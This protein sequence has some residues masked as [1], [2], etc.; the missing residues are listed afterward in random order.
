MKNII[1][2]LLLAFVSLT[3]HAEIRVPAGANIQ[4]FINSG[5]GQKIVISGGTY[6]AGFTCVSGLEIVSDG[7]VTITSSTAAPIINLT[8]CTDV[9]LSGDFEIVGNGPS[10]TG[11]PSSQVVDGAQTGITLSGNDRI[12]IDGKIEIHNI[13]GSA[14]DVQ[15]TAVAWKNSIHIRGLT[16]HDAYRGMWL[17]NVAEYVTTSDVN[18]YNNLFGIQVD[19]GNNTF[20][21]AKTIYNS[22]GVKVCGTASGYCDSAN[23]AHG[24]FVALESN[25]NT[26]D[27]VVVDVTVGETFSGCHFIADQS[28]SGHGKIQ[29]INSKGINIIGGQIAAD[30]SLDA[31]SVLSLQSN[32][33]RPALT[34]TPIVAAGGILYAKNNFTDTGPW[35]NNN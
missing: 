6:T 32:Y 16:V 7:H 13:K 20:I 10:Y 8:G 22:V 34:N 15:A 2:T 21:N 3:A 4:Q 28:G 30:I 35:A 1:F 27:L 25:H 23:N 24:V 5:A 17:H 12:D 19:S 29:I 11:Y 31:T 26:Y 14:V 33:V 18:A 9:K